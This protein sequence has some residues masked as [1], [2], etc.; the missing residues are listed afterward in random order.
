MSKRDLADRILDE[1]RALRRPVSILD[2]T[3]PVG[4]ASRQQ[5]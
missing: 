5:R 1:V 3:A 4:I 2:E